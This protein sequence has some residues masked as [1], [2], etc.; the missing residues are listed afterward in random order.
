MT[1]DVECAL[2]SLL[3]TAGLGGLGPNTVVCAWPDSWRQRIAGAARV[4]QILTSAHA[5]NMALILIKGIDAWPGS[6]QQLARAVDVWWVVHDGGLLLLLSI[7]LRKHRTWHS[8]PLRVFCVCHAEDNPQDLRA[9]VSQFLYQMRISAKLQVVQLLEGEGLDAILPTRGARTWGGAKANKAIVSTQLGK[10]AFGSAVTE[11]NVEAPRHETQ[12][13][14]APVEKDDGLGVG[15]VSVEVVED[16]ASVGAEEGLGPK[17]RTSR[18]FN[19]VLRK[20]SEES[21][22]VMTNLPLPRDADS[23]QEY[24]AHLDAL[25]ADVPRVLLVAGQKDADVVTMYS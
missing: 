12:T 7:I 5:F 21:A 13:Y 16:A 22:L 3:Q 2:D 6:N 25:V 4:K 10:L 14:D 15:G 9:T 20:Y 11:G 24:M 19:R 23:P 18:A 1:H 8:C 17:M